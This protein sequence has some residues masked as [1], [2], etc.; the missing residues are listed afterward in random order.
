MLNVR[1]TLGAVW[2]AATL[3][4]LPLAAEAT[5]APQGARLSEGAPAVAVATQGQQSASYEAVAGLARSEGLDITR[6]LPAREKQV[7]DDLISAHLPVL[8]K[9]GVVSEKEAA[10]LAMVLDGGALPPQELKELLL[11]VAKKADQKFVEEAQ[12]ANEKLALA[13][14][15]T[16]QAGIVFA[17]ALV[18][19]ALAAGSL[20]AAS[21]YPTWS[22]AAFISAATVTGIL[23]AVGIHNGVEAYN[24]QQSVKG[25]LAAMNDLNDSTIDILTQSRRMAL[26]RAGQDAHALLTN[27]EFRWIVDTIGNAPESK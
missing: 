26:F 6:P 2:A 19:C 25:T 3:P 12:H 21:R 18:A 22:K 7:C 13:N 10:Q 20:A 5:E 1:A 9:G 14:D 11:N 23:T 27:G 15:A 17:G 16:G 4:G 8:V 24:L